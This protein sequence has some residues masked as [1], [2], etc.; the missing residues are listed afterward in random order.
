MKRFLYLLIL[1]SVSFLIFSRVFVYA[2]GNTLEV[3]GE[4]LAPTAEL[5]VVDKIKPSESE[6]EIIEKIPAPSP[7]FTLTPI[8]ENPPL[9][10]TPIEYLPCEVPPVVSDPISLPQY[11]V[12]TDPIPI[13]PKPILT[14][15][16]PIKLRPVLDNPFPIE[17]PL[18]PSEN[19]KFS[20][21]IEELIALAKTDLAQRLGIKIEEI[22]VQ[23]IVEKAWSNASLGCPEKGKLYVAVIT[24][25]YLIILETGGKTY[26][27][28][29][30]TSWVRFCSSLDE[31]KHSNGDNM[32][33]LQT[34]TLVS[35][36]NAGE[37]DHNKDESSNEADFT[38]ETQAETL[39]NGR[40]TIMKRLKRVW[41]KLLS[42][43]LRLFP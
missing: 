39:P 41:T 22:S 18:P 21:S 24:P 23:S 40:S 4:V 38:T 28:R 8:K 16:I 9:T 33:D 11:P 7:T 30:S 25:G 29:A 31:T 6:F 3:A 13:D 12:L 1:I 19:P 14:N 17:L 43:N 20:K 10:L 32:N 34:E 15:P 36:S 37:F 26:D 5:E 27:Y 2:E 42:F 35:N